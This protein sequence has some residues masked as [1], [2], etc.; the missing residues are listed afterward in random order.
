MVTVQI[1]GATDVKTGQSGAG[2]YMRAKGEYDSYKIPLGKMSNHEAEFHAV[3]EA[4][5]ICN[6][7]FPGEILAFQTDSQ[8]VVDSIEKNYAKNKAFQNLLSQI[9]E[10]SKNHPYFFIKW[11]PSNQNNQA[12]LLAKQAIWMTNEKEN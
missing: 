12:D 8:I 2:I 4:L 6:E 3:I 5:K 1:D 10:L 9:N 7:Q 11:I